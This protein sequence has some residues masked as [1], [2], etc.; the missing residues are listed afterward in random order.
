M[1]VNE[2]AR[3]AASL[4][5]SRSGGRR[6]GRV[7]ALLSAGHA[8]TV[9]ITLPRSARKRLRTGHSLRAVLRVR[10][11]DSEGNVRAASRRLRFR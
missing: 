1:K 9:R 7:R 5:L 6:L 2:Q 4:E 11:T 3:M 8:R 10:V